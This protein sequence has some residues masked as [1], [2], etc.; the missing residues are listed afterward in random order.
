MATISADLYGQ[1]VHLL[2]VGDSVAFHYAQFVIFS[3]VGVPA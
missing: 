2:A 1:P 3:V